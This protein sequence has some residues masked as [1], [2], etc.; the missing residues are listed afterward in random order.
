M[1]SS[2]GRLFVFVGRL[3]ARLPSFRGRTRAFLLLFE[4]LGLKKSHV[5][6]DTTLREPTAFRVR[7]DLHSWLQRIAF[8]TGEYEADTARFLM[9][10]HEASGRDGALLDVGANVG[11][12]SIP[13]AL[14]LALKGARA[15]NARQVV[16]IEA[17]P[18]NARALRENVH[19]SGTEDL[20]DV[21]ESAVGEAV[22]T[23]E[24][25]VEGNLAEGEG[26]GT[27][28]IL[29][30]KSTYECVR[31]PL[32]VTTLDGLVREGRLLPSCTVMKIDTDGYDLKVLQGG[33]EFLRKTRPVIFG[34]FSAHCMKWHGQ[35]IKDVVEFAGS[36]SYEVWRKVDDGTWR[37]SKDLRREA[38]EQDLLLVPSEAER[39]FDWCL[40]LG[41][42]ELRA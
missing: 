7:L 1:T 9:K 25:Q 37:F 4:A 21:I 39:R 2:A 26:S 31:I 36:M 5:L 11:L 3:S 28:S 33:A 16:C 35:T 8:L 19:L 23:V 38:F 18:A 29:A 40:D 17:V 12:V 32:L 42:S 13:A 6:V 24:I 41:G 15:G 10:L 22:K 14:L 20:I 34:E 27:A 30:E